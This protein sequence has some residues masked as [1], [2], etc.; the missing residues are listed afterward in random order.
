MER[1]L[2]LGVDG[3]MTDDTRALRDVMDRARPWAPGLGMSEPRD[4]PPVALDTRTLRARRREQRGWYFYDWANSAFPTTVVTVFLGPYLTRR[5]DRGR[6]D[7]PRVRRTRS[8]S[9][10]RAQASTTRS[11]VGALG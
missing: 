1:L 2:D 3:I 9:T 5:R 7:A 6:P 11:S 4:R 8:A 10:I